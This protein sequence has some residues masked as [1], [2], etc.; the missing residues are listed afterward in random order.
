MN[1]DKDK[2]IQFGWY[3]NIGVGVDD[4]MV[5]YVNLLESGKI[6]LLWVV[7]RSFIEDA[8]AFSIY[9]KTDKKFLLVDTVSSAGG[10]FKG[11][12][13]ARAVY[14]FCT[15]ET[16][17]DYQDI[18]HLLGQNICLLRFIVKIE[19]AEHDKL[20]K[21][22]KEACYNVS[23]E[24]FLLERVMTQEQY[25]NIL[26]QNFKHLLTEMRTRG[27]KSNFV[28]VEGLCLYETRLESV[29]NW[30]SRLVAK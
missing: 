22:K 16:F 1:S 17:A 19:G 18:H 20:H 30:Q 8:K 5:V 29:E 11:K 14:E 24:G 4:E 13:L 28:Y 26:I 12:N 7:E 9:S 10:R 27:I 6:P 25:A 21:Q 23:A 3:R 2:A 15:G